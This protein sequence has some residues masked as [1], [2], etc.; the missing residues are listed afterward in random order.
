LQHHG[1]PRIGKDA[2]HQ[3]VDI[4]AQERAFH[5]VRDYLSTITLGWPEARPRLAR[6]LPGGRALCIF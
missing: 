1:L 4:R 3:A 5:P 6:R 2:T